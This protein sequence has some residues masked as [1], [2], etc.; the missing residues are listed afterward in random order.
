M[1]VYE[2]PGAEG[3]TDWGQH[4]ENKGAGFFPKVRY[5]HAIFLKSSAALLNEFQKCR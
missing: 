3:E 4:A 1:T 5:A 2:P